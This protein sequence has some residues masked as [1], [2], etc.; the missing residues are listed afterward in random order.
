MS[1]LD[2]SD[3]AT[4][5]ATV[6]VVEDE[7]S[8][9][10]LISRAL[11]RF[12]GEI[13]VVK[14]GQEA[15][16][17]LLT[18]LPDIV[19]SDLNLPDLSGL[20]LLHQIHELRPGL[21]VVVMTS[22][23]RLEDAVSA[24]REGAWDYMVKQFADDFRDR[25]QLVVTRCAERKLLQLREIQLRAER[26][27]FWS[28]VR[29]ATDGVAIVNEEGL[30]VFGN[31]ALNTFLGSLGHSGTEAA[32]LSG[33]DSDIR[34]RV[35]LRSLIASVDLA[36]ADE[37]ARQLVQGG[38]GLWKSE[39]KIPAVGESDA[40]EPRT[41]EITLTSFGGSAGANYRRHVVWVRDITLRKAQEKFQRDLLST[42]SH[43]LKG[44]LGAIITSTELLLN[45]LPKE[46]A[47]MGE[48]VT[49]MGSCARNCISLIDELL[50]ARRIQD[51]VLVV[52]PRWSSVDE[53]IS[54][55]V[56]DYTTSAR[57]KN[58]EI[59]YQPGSPGERI[60]VDK[61]G[62]QRVLGNL[63]SNAIK[64]TPK[65]GEIT[66]QVSRSSGECR[67]AVQ[68]NGCGIESDQYH[69]LFERYTRLDKHQEVSGTGL[70]LFV[71]KSIVD[72]HNGKIEVKSKVGF[73][74]TF[75]LV[76]PDGPQVVAS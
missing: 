53:Q 50:S 14:N 22:S 74:T 23:S 47:K 52:R 10:Q 28:A 7:P 38:G 18:S 68:D 75:I 73:G 71:T 54:D 30:V 66:V 2:Y 6:L 65:A 63:L 31:E 49:R 9:A 5:F 37:L 41:F 72:A 25:L 39:I 70:G 8:H 15:I 43:D 55:I 44:P 13:Q 17:A 20:D 61:L 35:D 48:L 4:L 67:V 19:F 16:Q 42:T 12:V 1:K 36:V 64:F 33:E 56:L 27:A 45:Q 51:G 57:A 29:A 62:F 21:P 11:K 58:I 24:M 32:E 59:R 34:A 40:P 69:T 26:D 60:Y 76:F 46:N 3:T